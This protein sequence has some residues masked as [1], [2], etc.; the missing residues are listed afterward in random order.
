MTAF[1]K[2]DQ[3]VDVVCNFWTYMMFSV[4]TLIQNEIG[5]AGI[6]KLNVNLR[7]GSDIGNKLF[8]RK[9]DAISKLN[10]F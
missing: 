10:K 4:G 8:I 7:L 9:N 5:L 3:T 1:N 6:T 2:T